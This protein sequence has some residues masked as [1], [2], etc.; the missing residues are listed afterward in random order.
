MI[1][2]YIIANLI[3]KY[4]IL[5]LNLIFCFLFFNFISQCLII[6]SDFISTYTAHLLEHISLPFLC[7]LHTLCLF[8]WLSFFPVPQAI[9]CTY[10]QAPMQH[11]TVVLASAYRLFLL[12]ISLAGILV[13]L[14]VDD[15]SE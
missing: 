11:C 8:D 4:Y 6:E 7:F 2:T 12:Y 5:L 9:Y 3:I 13:R 14:V 1:N 15:C 10:Y